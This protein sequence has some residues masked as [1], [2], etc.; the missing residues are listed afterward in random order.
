[1]RKDNLSIQ[2]SI[3][4]WLGISGGIITMFSNFQTLINLADWARVISTKW[5]SF[6]NCLWSHFFHFFKIEIHVTAQ[7][8]ITMALAMVS[9]AIG[10]YLTNSVSSSVKEEWSLRA[11]NVFRKNILLAVLLFC[12]AIFLGNNVI[13]FVNWS[14]H[15]AIYFSIF[16]YV[17]YVV[18]GLSIFVGVSHW[19]LRAGI[20]ATFSAIFFSVVFQKAAETLPSFEKGHDLNS[21]LIGAG[22]SILAAIL[23][24]LIAPPIQFAKRLI[25]LLLG[26][27]ILLGMNELSKFEIDLTPNTNDVR[28]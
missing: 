21:V 19:P 11:S 13:S 20:T 15:P 4:T 5:A 9:M 1:M 16:V 26:I 12:L 10:A 27:F 25:F 22:F 7:F 14:E 23:T 28:S 17:F 24:L 2:G 8:Q 18:Y 3:L 6:I